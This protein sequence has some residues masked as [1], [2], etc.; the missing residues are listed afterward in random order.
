MLLGFLRKWLK[1]NMHY[2]LNLKNVK[3][4]VLAQTK[5]PSGLSLSPTASR[6]E[7]IGKSKNR[8]KYKK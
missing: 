2:K 1:I 3:V 4:A 7:C 8:T 5:G 6:S